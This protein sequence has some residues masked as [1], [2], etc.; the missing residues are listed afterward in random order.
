MSSVSSPMKDILD[1]ETALE[2]KLKAIGIITKVTKG[3]VN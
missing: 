1:T 3:V 2:S